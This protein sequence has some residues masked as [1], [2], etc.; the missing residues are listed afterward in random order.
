[1]EVLNIKEINIKDVEPKKLELLVPDKEL[2]EYIHTELKYL[3]DNK[4]ERKRILIL[5]DDKEFRITKKPLDKE[6]FV[7]RNVKR[8]FDRGYT[9]ISFQTIIQERKMIIG[10]KLITL[11]KKYNESKN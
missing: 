4:P 3:F 5:L 10:D 6:T 1:M 11:N 2:N 8:W 9:K 7:E